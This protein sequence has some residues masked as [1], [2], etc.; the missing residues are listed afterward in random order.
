MSNVINIWIH[1]RE[2]HIREES[3][4]GDPLRNFNGCESSKSGAKA[5]LRF[6]RDESTRLDAKGI[7]G[8]G[9]VL[10]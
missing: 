3:S 8:C 1:E 5:L 9:D 7:L 6:I 10:D 2:D 4:W